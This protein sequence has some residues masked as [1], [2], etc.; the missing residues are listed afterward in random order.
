MRYLL[1]PDLRQVLHLGVPMRNAN[2]EVQ[3]RLQAAEDLA[4]PSG[5]IYSG[6]P[7]SFEDPSHPKGSY[8]MPEIDN[9]VVFG[10]G[11]WHLYQSIIGNT[12]GR[13]RI[14][15]GQNAI[16]FQQNR[17]D[18]EYLQMNFDVPD[19]ASKVT[20]WYGSYYTDRSSTFTLEY[21]IDQGETWHV[22]GEPISDAHSTAESANAKQAVFLMDIKQPVRFRVNKKGLGTSNNLI[23]N[24]RLGVDDIAVFKSY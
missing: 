16:R 23:S 21:S 8:N 6:W 15:S 22:V 5:K 4:F 20:L 9:N 2:S 14:V 13:D 19:G 3:L 11:E 12:A 7:E 1:L 24:G 17:S 10:T 18:D